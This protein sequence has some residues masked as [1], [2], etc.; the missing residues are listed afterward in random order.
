M[1]RLFYIGT[2]FFWLAVAI[3]GVRATRDTEVGAAMSAASTERRITA[4]ELS[5]HAGASDCWMA[6]QG[7]VYDLSAYLPEHPAR[8]EVI[9]RW[10]GKEASA[11]YATKDKGR[12]HSAA[13]DALLPNYRIGI[14]SGQSG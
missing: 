5:R 14:L 3:L 1:R 9:L 13:A 7:V 10:C 6:I 8:P 2:A 4:A 12:P 11:A